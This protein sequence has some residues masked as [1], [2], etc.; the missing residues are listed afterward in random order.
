MS[1]QRETKAKDTIRQQMGK[2]IY[3][4][5]CQA[6]IKSRRNSWSSSLPY[7]GHLGITEVLQITGNTS[8]LVTD[9]ILLKYMFHLPVWFLLSLLPHIERQDIKFFIFLWQSVTA[10][11]RQNVSQF[12]P[13]CII[14][15]SLE[16]QKLTYHKCQWCL[17]ACLREERDY[18]NTVDTFVRKKLKLF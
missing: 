4:P 15:I 16:P 6:T 13:Q 3:I 14:V 2:G 12:S 5:Q 10:F 8:P 1:S 18:K 17:E 9:H 11:S 7:L